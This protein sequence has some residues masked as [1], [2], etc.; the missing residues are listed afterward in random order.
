MKE[1]IDKKFSIINK[2][3]KPDPKVVY[4]LP[5]GSTTIWLNEY[6]D[7][8][9]QAKVDEIV[10]L[11]EKQLAEQNIGMFYADA[12]RASIELIKEN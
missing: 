10:E 9:V 2:H 5:D 4:T 12:I 11:L 1:P 3:G 7:A 6:V 8:M